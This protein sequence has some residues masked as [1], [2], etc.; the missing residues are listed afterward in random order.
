MRIGVKPCSK[1]T[2]RTRLNDLSQSGSSS[3]QVGSLLGDSHPDQPPKG[4]AKL[5]N[6][7]KQLFRS[8][9]A[10]ILETLGGEKHGPMVTI[11]L[12]QPAVG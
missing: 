11:Y 1:N 8:P 7:K 3:N 6:F 12:S 10:G 4:R 5:A 9:Q 2:V